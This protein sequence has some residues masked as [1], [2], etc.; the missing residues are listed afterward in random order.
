[1][2]PLLAVIKPKEVPESPDLAKRRDEAARPRPSPSQLRRTLGDLGKVDLRRGTFSKKQIL[3]PA[4]ISLNVSVIDMSPGKGGDR[5]PSPTATRSVRCQQL[6]KGF[7]IT[8][9][10][11][12]ESVGSVTQR[13][14]KM[15]TGKK[16]SSDV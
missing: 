14:M 11:L 6:S 5:T 13:L 8:R 4:S 15:T 12:I 16:T 1:M 2:S 3:P 9:S 10:A 7:T